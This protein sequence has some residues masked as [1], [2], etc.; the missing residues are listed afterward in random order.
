MTN[1]ISK[2]AHKKL[3]SWFAAR[4]V[5]ALMGE[6]SA[7]KST[8]LN[9]LLDLEVLPTKVTAT[10]LP[11][12]WLTYSPT[13]TCEGLLFN[14]KVEP[15]DIENLGEDVRDNYVLLRMGLNLS[16]IHI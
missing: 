5:F 15:V 3:A 16:L 2:T 4:P 11:P 6:Y 13:P 9:L 12:V 8:L 10:N 7:G 14:G 1:T